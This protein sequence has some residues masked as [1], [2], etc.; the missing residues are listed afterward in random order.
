[1]VKIPDNRFPCDLKRI[2]SL[3][4]KN[5]RDIVTK[6][7]FICNNSLESIPLDRAYGMCRPMPKKKA[8]SLP[9]VCSRPC[10]R[11]I[12]NRRFLKK[13][14]N[15]VVKFSNGS[16]LSATETLSQ[17]LCQFVETHLFTSDIDVLK[18]ADHQFMMRTGKV[19]RRPRSYT[20]N[21][22]C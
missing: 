15:T 17:I 7:S 16:K 9:G 14:N 21:V 8:R 13:W 12:V 5:S 6:L 22:T 11:E 3:D 1:M 19:D 4:G 18:V 2:N 20:E 10:H